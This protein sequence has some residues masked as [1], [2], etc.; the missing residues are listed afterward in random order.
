MTESDPADAADPAGAP[1]GRD[2]RRAAFDL[3]RR[4]LRKGRALEQALADNPRLDA[5]APRDRAFA[6]H[7]AATTLRRLGQIDA[8]LAQFLDKPLKPK[9]NAV[10]DLLRLGTA[11]LLFLQVPAHA[12][13]D[14]TVGLAAGVRV[15]PHRGLLNAVLRRID[16]ERDGL[17]E[18]Q[19][20]ARLNAPDWLYARWTEAY[21]ADTAHAIAAAHLGEP[22]LD[23]TVKADPDAWADRLGAQRLPTGSLRLTGG[24]G[25]VRR[26]PGYR[27]GAWWVQD[28]AAALP[29]R[30]LG[31]V[32]GR[33]VFDLCAAPGGKTA[34]LA[35]AGAHV[36]AVD[37]SAER[38]R[39]LEA[40]LQRL[41]LAAATVAAELQTWTPPDPPDAVLLDAPCTAT[42]T[43][44]RHPDIAHLKR[45]EDVRQMAG[46]QAEL[47]AAAAAT[48]P[49]G[50]TLVYAVC[51]LEPEE[52]VERVEALLRERSDLQ[53][54]P[55]D[56]AELGV[57]GAAITAAGDLR[58]LPC[59]WPDLGGLDGFYAARL[60]KR[61]PLP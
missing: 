19:D 45:P 54:R 4:V 42:G 14:Q 35:A 1:A 24:T 33:R 2:A 26:L 17:T 40:N 39:Q 43:L 18:G 58:T 6:R 57:P 16:R 50:A 29:A 27:D 38:L 21:G 61:H 56:P 25:E 8:V 12:A 28:A 34:Q 53:R 44:R 47:L 60:V 51:S 37:R 23:L 31:D 15:G 11:Q 55:V 49:A 52:G 7:L 48:L 46:L 10:Q 9:L 30:L 20:A 59:H 32:A 36:M 22:P 5:L 3:I 13:V 41:D